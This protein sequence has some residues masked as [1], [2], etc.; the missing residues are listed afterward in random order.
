MLICRETSRSVGKKPHDNKNG[1]SFVVPQTMAMFAASNPQGKGHK[2]RTTDKAQFSRFVPLVVTSTHDSFI[3]ELSKQGVSSVMLAYAMK[4]GKELMPA[5]SKHG[6][7]PEPRIINRRNFTMLC[8]LYESMQYD[9][10]VLTEVGFAML[11]TSNLKD[12]RSLLSGEMP[13][14]PQE[15]L[16]VNARERKQGVEGL[17][18]KAAWPVAETKIQKFKDT[19]RQDIL[20]V[21]MH[22]LVRHLN[23]PGFDLSDDQ[24]DNVCAFFTALPKDL[25]ATGLRKIILDSCPRQAYYRPK[26][27]R[28]GASDAKNA[29]VFAKYMA[30]VL[31]GARALVDR[32]MAADAAADED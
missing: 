14:D 8:H 28:H 11:G 5:N 4:M 15:I 22:R 18:P 13:L 2:V 9:D 17:E 29:G 21:T 31:S 12:I 30:S 1:N 10:E 16:G 26:F 23:D 3:M 7:L 19:N 32:E 25:S 27:T 24:L 6:V 20:A